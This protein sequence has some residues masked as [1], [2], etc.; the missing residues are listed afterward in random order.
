MTRR[1]VVPFDRSAAYWAARARRHYTPA[2]LPEAARLMR[3]A[4]ETS[5]D[6]AVALELAEI[7]SGMECETAAERC[8]LKAVAREGLTGGAC[9]AAARCAF[10]RGDEGLAEEALELCLRLDPE[11]PYADQAQW[12]LENHPWEDHPLPPRCARSDTLC[13]RGRAA[14][15]EGDLARARDLAWQAWAKGRFAD[16]ALLFA[17]FLRLPQARL[18]YLAFAAKRSPD[19]LPALLML[20][21]CSLQAGNAPQAQRQ[22]LRAR[23]LCDTLSQAEAYCAAA[24]EMHQPQ[25]ALSLCAEA[26]SRAPAS[27]EYLRLKYLSLRRTGDQA[28]A[29][30]ALQTLLDID[31]DDAAGLW[32]RRHPEDIR[33]YAPRMMLYS[34]LASQI[35]SAVPPRK[36]GPLN[37]ALHLL[38]ISMQDSLDVETIYRLTPPLWRRMRP[39]ERAACDRRESQALL[40][41]SVC[42][43]TLAGRPESA[44]ALIAAAPGKKRILRTVH[45]YLQRITEDENNALH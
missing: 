10:A 37:R 18:P 3:K 33:L 11:G 31:P 27:V 8:L 12:L 6:G 14:L 26:L 39:A 30:R 1:T 16:S 41:L 17:S 36:T 5:G 20:A 44:A 45:R 2:R 40:C 25:L 23:A 22:M 9:C 19:S 42:V 21:Q 28:G 34:A 43:L 32:Y 24:W 4:L 29:Q 7:Y 13:R 38:V 35:Y 15:L